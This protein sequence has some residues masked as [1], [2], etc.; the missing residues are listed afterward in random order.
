MTN[1]QMIIEEIKHYLMAC[2]SDVFE[3]RTNV[4]PA[5]S[6]YVENTISR[7]N[8]IQGLLNDLSDMS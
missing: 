5:E 8:Y 7:I 3:L 1:Q 6:D 4:H 2:K